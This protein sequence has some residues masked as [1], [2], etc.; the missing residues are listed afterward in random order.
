MMLKF[1][2]GGVVQG[3]KCFPVTNGIECLVD[4]VMLGDSGAWLFTAIGGRPS[5]NIREGEGGFIEAGISLT[6]RSRVRPV[7]ML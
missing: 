7:P 5:N 3:K 2:L 1:R 4:N 6:S